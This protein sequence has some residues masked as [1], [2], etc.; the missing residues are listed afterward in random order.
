MLTFVQ[1]ERL[2]GI[3]HHEAPEQKRQPQLSPHSGRGEPEALENAQKEDES[4][5]LE[6]EEVAKPSKRMRMERMRMESASTTTSSSPPASTQRR[7]ATE[8]RVD[9]IMLFTREGQEKWDEMR[10]AAAEQ[11]SDRPPVAL[12]KTTENQTGARSHANAPSPEIPPNLQDGFLEQTKAY[13]RDPI[14]RAKHFPDPLAVRRVR[15][16]AGEQLAGHQIK[17]TVDATLPHWAERHRPFSQWQDPVNA[18]IYWVFGE[19]R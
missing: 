2:G 7:T 11:I 5:E 16:W 18:L 12:L 8:I 17:P 13:L 3:E 4:R 19:S 15:V 1:V 14:Q 10:A 6:T 9:K